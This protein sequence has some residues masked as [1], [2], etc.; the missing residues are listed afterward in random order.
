MSGRP[1]RAESRTAAVLRIHAR[2]SMPVPRPT[3]EATSVAVRIAIS[4][5]AAVVLPM[6]M[7]PGIR[8]SAPAS[9]SSSA[10]VHAGDERPLGLVPRHRRSD[11]EVVAAS[12]DL[13]RGD[14]VGDRAAVRVRPVDVDADVDDAHGGAVRLGEDV[15]RGA[16]GAGSCAPSAR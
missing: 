10:I 16:A 14:G 8:R 3:T 1:R 15:H 5:A 4:V 2:S 13:E 11:G 7:S 9:I 6:P 12:A